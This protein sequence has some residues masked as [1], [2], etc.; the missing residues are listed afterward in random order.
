MLDLSYI[1]K[2]IN[3]IEKQKEA[4]INIVEKMGFKI[5]QKNEIKTNSVRDFNLDID[6]LKDLRVACIMDRF[7]LDSYSPE[8]TVLEVTPEGWKNEINEFKPH[9]LFIESA[10]KGKN[11]LWYRKIANGSKEYFEMTSYC[12]D[13]N[14]PIV[15]W[16]KEDPIYTDIFM[17]AARMADFVFTTDIDCV[18]KYKNSLKH[19][20]VYHL[21]F[22]AQP[23]IHN[24]IEKYDRKDKYSFAGAY[25][26][27]YVNRCKVFDDFS[28][29]FIETKGFDIYDRNYKNARPEHKFPEI[30]DKYILRSLDPSEIDIAYKG[31]NFGVNMNSVQQSQTMFARRLFE[32][33]ASNTVT[34]GNYSRGVKNFFGDLTIC[35][36]DGETLK[37]SINKWCNNTVDFRKYR[38]L[39][40]RK[41]LNEHLYEDRLSYIVEKVFNKDIKKPLPNINILAKVSDEKEFSSIIKSFKRQKYNSKKLYIFAEYKINEN[42]QDVIYL[43][44]D[45]IKEDI[46][47]KLGENGYITI[48][49][50]KNYYGE[51]Y[52]LDFA[53]STRYSDCDG[54]GK[55]DF[56]YN[57]KD[58]ISIKSINNTYKEVIN[59]KIDRAMFK[60]KLFKSN[61]INELWELS[62]ITGEKL[63][64]VDEFNF[65]ENLI[66][67]NCEVVDDIIISDQ[68]IPME[69]I[70]K[71]A[72]HIKIDKF[73][74]LG[75]SL[76]NEELFNNMKQSKDSSVT[77]NK[78][79]N[80]VK[81]M[82]TLDSE[83]SHYINIERLFDVN[84]FLEDGHI[85]LVFNGVGSLDCLG[86][87]IF[88]DNNQKKISPAF[89]KLNRLFNVEVPKSAVFFKLCLRIKGSGE[90]KIS[91]ILVGADENP[92]EKAC[93]VSR[94]N[95][96]VLSN[97]YPSSEMLY[98]NM[99][100]HKRMIAY[101]EDGFVYDVMRMNIYA[102]NEYREFEGI[103]VVEGQG[104]TLV[105]ILETGNIDTVCVHFLDRQ[106]W[107]VL[108]GFKDKIK[109]IV[110]LHGAEIQPWWRR[111]FNYKTDDELEMA[112][113][114][115][116]LRMDFWKEVFSCYKEMKVH[117]VYV[118]KYFFD[119]IMEDYKI[120]MDD[121]EYSIIHNCIDTN[122]FKYYKK[123][124]E[125]RKNIISIRPY[126]SQ[127]YG[128]DLA[129]KA[130]LELSNEDFFENIN[131]TFIGDGDLFDET[132]KPLKKFTNVTIK[133]QFLR[134]QQI[135]KIYE[136]SGVV[137][138]PTRGDTQGVSRDEAMSCGVVPITNAVAAIPE[139][140]DKKCGILAGEEDYIAMAKGIKN[141]Y[142][143][144][145]YFLD[146]SKNAANRVRNQTSKEFTID[147]EI[148]LINNIN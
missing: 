67:D 32:M 121:K 94:S 57:I 81:F 44:S 100:V 132:L 45:E 10:W 85:N 26:H 25:Y 12:Q 30:Y 106:M 123:N 110:W 74:S 29:F 42:I 22:A 97:H 55:A 89:T 130:V 83:I 122:L 86:T 125:A 73:Q 59:L 101:K 43:T 17:I 65:C 137:L 95:V 113:K 39:G 36:D 5:V 145:E 117:F 71:T 93:F 34:V 96:L 66:S 51:N 105:N 118:S 15:F 82:S 3:Y 47:S 75:L 23:K 40:L 136:N 63:L 69:T 131:F 18:K 139:F 112:K 84:E 111:K 1:D 88:Y 7:T 33:L 80:A 54:V 8:C 13:N 49:N 143:D 53:L 31:Y 14:I 148:Q 72:E 20:N 135:S 77:F 91:E 37:Q 4:V 87:C 76:S 9:M 19:D 41:V 146:L 138:V 60:N 28:K 48:F 52:L 115:S 24:P 98:R 11:D 126:S 27:K 108:K 56:Y 142:N 62:E 90:L 92:E 102:K 116:D 78:I 140:V 114:D 46:V 133:K 120:S 144:P 58:I 21:H 107:E 119:M 124:P 147:R 79:D 134:Q 35:T 64:S 2:R 99:F 50:S 16:N 141:L 128:N 70:E 129:V 68:G 103:N 6:N 127:I 109:I 61:T 104:E 38:L